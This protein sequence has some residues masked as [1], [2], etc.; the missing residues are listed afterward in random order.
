M[1]ISD[2]PLFP[3]SFQALLQKKRAARAYL[4]TGITLFLERNLSLGILPHE[5]LAP[6]NQANI[7][8]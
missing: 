7:R 6:W 2:R 1:K 4:T 3:I 8:H 5:T